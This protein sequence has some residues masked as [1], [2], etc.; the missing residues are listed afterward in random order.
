MNTLAYL[1]LLILITPVALW[2][3]SLRR[4]MWRSGRPYGTRNNGVSHGARHDT[5]SRRQAQGM[6]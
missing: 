1:L 2:V 4:G 3:Q 6:R 5:A